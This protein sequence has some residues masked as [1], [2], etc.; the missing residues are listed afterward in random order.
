MADTIPAIYEV[1]LPLAEDEATEPANLQTGNDVADSEEEIQIQIVSN[2]RLRHVQKKL[3]QPF[4]SGKVGPTAKPSRSDKK[5]KKTIAK[6]TCTRPQKL[7]VQKQSSVSK[8]KRLTKAP[9]KPKQAA[10]KRNKKKLPFFYKRTSFRAFLNFY[11]DSLKTYLQKCKSS[12][13]NEHLLS[14]IQKR[15]C[16]QQQPGLIKKLS[17]NETK[18]YLNC[19][20]MLCFSHQ[21]NKD[22]AYLVP[23]PGITYDMMRAPLYNHSELAIDSFF[24]HPAFAFLFVFFAQYEEAKSFSDLHTKKK[25]DDEDVRLLKQAVQGLSLDAYRA[26]NESEDPQ[27]KSFLDYLAET[28]PS[29]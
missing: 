9:V 29:D 15:F 6:A 8:S 3:W 7:V 1:L 17:Q 16:E 27:S 10:A 25:Q 4:S 21:Y 13:T 14:V 19:L 18:A 28:A 20:K 11:K 23:E 22:H 2:V 24:K 5:I 12:D 26:L